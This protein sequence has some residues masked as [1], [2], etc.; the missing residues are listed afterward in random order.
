MIDAMIFSWVASAGR[1]LVDEPALVHHVDAVADAEQLG[2]LRGDDDD[3]F[4]LRRPAR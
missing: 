3:A 2:H 4:A 1:H